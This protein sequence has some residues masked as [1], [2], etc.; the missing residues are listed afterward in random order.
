MMLCSYKKVAAICCVFLLCSSPVAF[1]RW[2]FR[3]GNIQDI[4][5]EIKQ[6]VETAK[7]SE[8]YL[9]YKQIKSDYDDIMAVWQPFTEALDTL[10]GTIETTLAENPISELLA[11]GDEIELNAKVDERTK[12]DF[13]HDELGN[14]T[15]GR[16]YNMDRL[17]AIHEE[18]FK[19]TLKVAKNS[20]E[21]SDELNQQISDTVK[22]QSGNG[23][24]HR[25]KKIMINI[26]RTIANIQN[27]QTRAQEL[28]ND[29]E[30]DIREYDNFLNASL[31]ESQHELYIPDS[32]NEV[33]KLIAENSR[34]K[35]LPR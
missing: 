2:H 5:N 13:L 3:G 29:I 31:A 21:L 15:E 17:N 30:G 9:Q 10:H 27:V 18:E 32:N 14:T 16:K 1:A 4:A 22:D 11:T 33:H 6:A 7:Q 20:D 35:E 26:S 24:A 28:V 8:I 12:F 34:M 19:N 23:Y 25:Q